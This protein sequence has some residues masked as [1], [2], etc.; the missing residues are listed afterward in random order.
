M[1]DCRVQDVVKLPVVTIDGC[2]VTVLTVKTVGVV[3]G[4]V[5]TVLSVVT[6]ADD[7]VVVRGTVG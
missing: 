2:D 6:G 4:V 3:N 5:V 7:A 1:N